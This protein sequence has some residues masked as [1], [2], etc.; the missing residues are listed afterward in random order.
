M[1]VQFFKIQDSRYPIGIT[2][3]ILITRSEKTADIDTLYPAALGATWAALGDCKLR[4]HTLRVRY[5]KSSPG[6]KNDLFRTRFR[7]SPV[8][9]YREILRWLESVK[10]V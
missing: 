10:F 5:A 2:S 1:L 6:L 8:T 3:A 7:R 9:A 4:A